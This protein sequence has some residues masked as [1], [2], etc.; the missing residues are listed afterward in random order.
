L[1]P[2]TKVACQWREA[3]NF[4]ERAYPVE[5]LVLHYTGM[6]SEEGALD[7]LCRTES[8]VSC[9]Y[10]V[11]TDGRV[12]Q[13]VPEGKR[14]WH[15]GVS[16]WRGMSD[17]NSRSIGIEIANPGHEFGYVRFPQ[18]QITSVI[19]LARDIVIRNRIAARDVVA[20]SDIAPMRKQ[21]PGELF[22]WGRLAKAGVGLWIAPSRSRSGATLRQGD[23]GTAVAELRRQLSE[24]GYSIDITGDYDSHTAATV[25]AF[26]RHFR[27]AEISGEAD[28][29]TRRTLARL[30]KSLPES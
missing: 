2:D 11:F 25:T 5:V 15:A 1:K 18:R 27:Q 21:D 13:S 19:Q 23:T 29:S 12:F 6:Q 4:D 8:K 14:A 24:Y 26:Q 3:A 28:P 22:P 7:W 10:F 9:H 20:H 17:L 30:L 16:S